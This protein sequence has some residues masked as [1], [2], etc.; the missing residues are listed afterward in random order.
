[1]GGLLAQEVLTWLEPGQH[2]KPC[3]EQPHFDEPLTYPLQPRLFTVWANLAHMPLVTMRQ[4]EQDLIG[5]SEEI[6]DKHGEHGTDCDVSW[7][8]R[9]PTSDL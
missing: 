2:V 8:H 1:M 4:K 9:A 3:Q 5:W 7:L 6:L